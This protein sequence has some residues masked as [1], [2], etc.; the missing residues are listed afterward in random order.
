MAPAF[1]TDATIGW[2]LITR[3]QLVSPSD[4]QWPFNPG[5]NEPEK[6]SL[7][8]ECAPGLIWVLITPVTDSR[9]I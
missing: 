9:P 7:G 3:A 5:W 6:S 4:R 1:S 8:Q 2:L